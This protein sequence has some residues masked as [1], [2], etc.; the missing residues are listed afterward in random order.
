MKIIHEI[1][2]FHL[3]KLDKKSKQNK[4]GKLILRTMFPKVP[5][6]LLRGLT[7]VGLE[8]Y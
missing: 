8:G 7:H 3:L 5:V 2:E 1:S 4:P 6:W